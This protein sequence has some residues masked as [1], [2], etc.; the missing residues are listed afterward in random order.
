MLLAKAAKDWN[1]LS[2]V[3]ILQNLGLVLIEKM[4]QPTWQSERKVLLS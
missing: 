4:M 2:P 1:K 3:A